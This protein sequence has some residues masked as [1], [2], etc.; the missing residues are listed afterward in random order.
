VSKLKK[1]LRV[2]Y[3]VGG[4]IGVLVL[5][6]GITLAVLHE[7]RPEGGRTGPGAD[8]FARRIERAVDKEAWDRTGAIRFDFDGRQEHLWDLERDLS[9]VRW[10]DIEVLQRLD[11][12]DGVAF[13]DG[14]PVSEERRAELV[15][16]AWAFF[17]NDTF[18]LNPFVKLFDE[19][20]ER[21]IVTLED[22]SKALLITYSSGGVTPGDAYLWIPGEGDLP[23]A[24][25][26]WV[27]VFPI[28]GVRAS[29]DEWI[30]LSTG[31]KVATHHELGP[32]TLELR[33]IEGAATLAELEPGPDPFAALLE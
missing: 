2:L 4:V 13:E 9:R 23:V 26:M 27:S 8:D 11:R 15:E 19:G 7:G 24:G 21:A 22:G 12:R 17:C 29:W 18:W 31:A 25:K 1:A 16:K 5:A 32:F 20:T 30:T 14:Q 10:G 33:D 3:W 6:L 28:G